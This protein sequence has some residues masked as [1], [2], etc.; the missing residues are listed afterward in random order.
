MDKNIS[1]IIPCYEMGGKGQEYLKHS[2]DIIAEQTYKDFEVI[3]L[4]HSTYFFQEQMAGL[5]SKYPF[6]TY[7]KNDNGRGSSS[8]NLN[9]GI[10]KATGKLIK[11]LFQDDFLFNSKSLENTVKA[12]KGGWLVSACESSPD[13]TTMT[14]PFYPTYNDNIHLGNNTI[15]SPS[16]L[17]MENFNTN[18]FDENLNW[19]MDCDYYKQLHKRYGKPDI[20][21]TITVV[22]R[23]HPDQQSNILNQKDKD[24]E[25]E[26]IKQKY[27]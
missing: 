24:E 11:I 7:Y 27:A 19:L 20:L 17:T 4:D 1:I 25:L 6:V 3:V 2:L 8:S 22:N 21:N 10:S 23:I 13:G 5:C 14:R 16:V 18:Q 12:F 9:F 15:S 26:Y